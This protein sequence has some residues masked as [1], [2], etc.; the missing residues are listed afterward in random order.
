MSLF[1]LF[2]R[3]LITRVILR[4]CNSKGIWQQTRNNFNIEFKKPPRLKERQAL[5]LIVIDVSSSEIRGKV[6][7]LEDNVPSSFLQFTGYLSLVKSPNS[8]EP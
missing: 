5:V 4:L 1:V 3:F 8:A 7:K 6:M 2:T